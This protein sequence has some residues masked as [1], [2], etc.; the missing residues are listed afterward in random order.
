MFP[1]KFAMQNIVLTRNND[2]EFV[3]P[4]NVLRVFKCSGQIIGDKINVSGDTI[5]ILA[6]VKTEPEFFPNYFASLVATKLASEF[7][8]PLI[9]D[10]NVFKMLMALYES[11]FQSAKFVDSTTSTNQSNIDNFSLINSR[12]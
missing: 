5:E 7:C 6:V 12:F 11:E 8:I 2:E 3:I 9:G 4:S 1:W 10:A